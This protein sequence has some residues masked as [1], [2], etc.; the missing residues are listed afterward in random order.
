[1]TVSGRAILNEETKPLLMRGQ[2]RTARP[3]AEAG[4]LLARPMHDFMDTPVGLHSLELGQERDGVYRDGLYYVPAGYRANRPA[5]LVVW[6]HGAGG[7]ADDSLA[8]L[9]GLADA[10]GLILLA[11]E[12]RR[13]TWDAIR[14]EFGPDVAFIDRSLRTVFSRYSVD[15]ARL[16]VAGFS[17]GASYALSLGLTNGDLFTHV[18]AFAPGFMA[19]EQ[20]RGRPRLFIAHGMHD[21]VLPIESCSGRIVPQLRRDSYEVRYREFD[22]PHTVPAAVVRE[23]IDWFAPSR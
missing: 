20:T 7:N 21:S 8:P 19:P 6:L 4:R 13:R 18:M 10:R 15:P 23:A 2:L 22:G 17:D 1:M 16:A 5:P 12:S 11:P 3:D 14:G 9:C